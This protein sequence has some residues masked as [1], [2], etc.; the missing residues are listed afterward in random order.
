MR[1]V[2][3]EEPDHDP[4]REDERHGAGR[5]C[6]DDRDGQQ[7]RRV[8][9]RFEKKSADRARPGREREHRYR[10]PAS[11]SVHE[12]AERGS[13]AD[14]EQGNADDEIGQVIAEGR[15]E[16]ASLRDLEEEGGG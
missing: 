11:S 13:A 16:H 4:A 2:I 8:D 10:W 1:R 12:P 3:A 9:V 14:A 6:D 7:R 15:A 5:V